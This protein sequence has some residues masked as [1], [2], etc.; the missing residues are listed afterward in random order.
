MLGITSSRYI[1]RHEEES[2]L[3]ALTTRI[4]R[5]IWA[6]SGGDTGP[7]LVFWILSARWTGCSWVAVKDGTDGPWRTPGSG[8]GEI[9]RCS[10]CHIKAGFKEPLDGPYCLSLF[11]NYENDRMNLGSL[12]QREQA[13]AS[14]NL[15]PEHETQLLS[16]VTYRPSP[17]E[18]RLKTNDYI[19]SSKI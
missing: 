1:Y 16:G 14:V 4:V 7:A 17:I 18:H 9:A 19:F 15:S 10:A 8:V 11:I 6:S 12:W 13:A 3:I 5:V 2:P